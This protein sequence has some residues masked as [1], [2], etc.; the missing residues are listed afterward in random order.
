MKAVV[1]DMDGVLFDTEKLAVKCWDDIGEEIGLGKVGYMVM[2]TLGRTREESV[3]I[4]QKEFGSRFNNDIFQAHYK[5]YLDKYYESNPVPVKEGVNEILSFLKK[6]NIKTAVA[7]SSS[8]SSVI[9]H[10]KSAGIKEY[11]NEIICGDMIEKSKPEPDIYLSAANALEVPGEDCYAV[12][13]SESGLIS[14][15]RANMKVIYVPDLYI[16]DSKIRKIIYREFGNLNEFR[17]YLETEEFI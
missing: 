10:L 12:E 3:K 16:A 6:H 4:F 17:D 13:D 9:H 1:F 2:K 14:A 5:A 7:S 11:F 8:E 15:Y